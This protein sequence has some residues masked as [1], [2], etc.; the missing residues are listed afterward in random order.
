[1]ALVIGIVVFVLVVGALFGVAWWSSGRS[2]YTEPGTGVA[3]RNEAENRALRH[4]NPP[5]PPSSGGGL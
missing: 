4:Y 3:D 2:R 1:M 5:P